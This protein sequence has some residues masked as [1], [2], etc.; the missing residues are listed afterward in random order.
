MLLETVAFWAVHRHRDP[1]PQQL[2]ESDVQTN[3]IELLVRSLEKE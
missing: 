3:V 2:V 1:S